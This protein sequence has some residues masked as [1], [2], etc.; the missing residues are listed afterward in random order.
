MDF[1]ADRFHMDNPKVWSNFVRFTNDRIRKGFPH[2][3]AKAVWE[4]IRWEMATPYD[5]DPKHSF[6]LNNN[7]PAVYAR[8]F[9]EEYPEHEGFFRTRMRISEFGPPVSGNQLGPR[10]FD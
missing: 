1:L 9:M 2:F 10:D 4:R 7:Y 6:K 5:L 3:G 8:W